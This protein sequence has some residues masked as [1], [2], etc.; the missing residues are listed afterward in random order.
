MDGEVSIQQRLRCVIGQVFII[1]SK[2]FTHVPISSISNKEVSYIVI[3]YF[4]KNSVII[5]NS[6][7]IIIITLTNYMLFA[8]SFKI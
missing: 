2:F 7:L 4:Q 5:M 8:I 6:I 3:F 1:D